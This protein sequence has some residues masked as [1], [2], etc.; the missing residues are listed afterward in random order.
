MRNKGIQIKTVR[1]LSSLTYSGVTQITSTSEIQ[2]IDYSRGSQW[3]KMRTVRPSLVEW[4]WRP[5]PWRRLQPRWQRRT[6]R[7]PWPA[8][9]RR[10]WGPGDWPAWCSRHRWPSHCPQNPNKGNSQQWPILY[11][12]YIL[13]WRIQQSSRM[14]RNR[15]GASENVAYSVKKSYICLNL[16]KP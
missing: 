8:A 14:E 16:I 9:G 13:P 15:G 10:P 6:R 4:P 7:R 12:Y 1:L 5:D 11:S 2:T 3:M